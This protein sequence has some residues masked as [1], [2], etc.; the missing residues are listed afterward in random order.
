MRFCQ[1]LDLQVKKV[2]KVLNLFVHKTRHAKGDSVCVAN[3]VSITHARPRERQERKI[4]ELAGTDLS[5]WWDMESRVSDSQ[6]FT[7]K[8]F[9]IY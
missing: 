5:V 3:K 2:G 7:L 1:D 8:N 6:N 4:T 9:F